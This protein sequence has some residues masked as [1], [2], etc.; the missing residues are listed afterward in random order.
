MSKTVTVP[1]PCNIEENTLPFFAPYTTYKAPDLPVRTLKNVFITY[2]GLAID[3]NG[4]VT[5]CYHDYPEQHEIHFREAAHFF[6]EADRDADK[7][8]ELTDD[9]TYLLIHHPWCNYYHWMCEAILRL[10]TVRDKIEE[11]VLL[12]PEHYKDIDFVTGSLAPFG[13][14]NIFYIPA[15]KSILVKRLCVPAIKPVCDSYDVEKLKGIRE[16]YLEH[17]AK[18]PSLNLGERLYLSRKKA[19]RKK[20]VNEDEVEDIMRRHGFTIICNEDYTF[21]EQVGIYSHARLLVS[22]HGSGLTNMLFMREGSGILEILK[23]RT[24][25][26]GRPSFV[27]WYQAAALGFRYYQQLMPWFQAGD[28]YFFGDFH[29]DTAVLERNV[30]ALI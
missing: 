15:N 13:L 1:L 6:Q 20:V 4:L 23:E 9:R 19:A 24:N 17:R 14:K 28:D 22:I 27:F 8:V 7:I 30:A 21:P 29:I 11:L 18:T 16:F 3:R 25:S 5:S 26:L 2:S 12:L 10:W